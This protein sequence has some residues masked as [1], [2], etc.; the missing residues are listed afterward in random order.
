MEFLGV[1]GTLAVNEVLQ[2]LTHS[3][4]G[5]VLCRRQSIFSW[6]FGSPGKDEARLRRDRLS[7]TCATEAT[8]LRA[9]IT[10]CRG[11]TF[12]VTKKLGY[13]DPYTPPATELSS[14]TAGSE[15]RGGWDWHERH[16]VIQSHTMVTMT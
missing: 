4:F 6:G 16:I 2:V 9:T 14:T 10:A 1:L 3:M 12:E 11:A 8:C 15:E 13:D 7:R 5:I